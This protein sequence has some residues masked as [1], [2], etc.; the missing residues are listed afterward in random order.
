[1]KLYDIKNATIT[2]EKT[3][4][5]YWLVILRIGAEIKDKILTDD[6]K[7]SLA[8]LKAFKKIANNT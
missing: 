5:G 4:N 6:Y 1:M 8:Y 2:Y 7:S 3:K